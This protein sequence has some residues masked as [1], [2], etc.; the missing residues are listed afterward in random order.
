MFRIADL[1]R[2]T[3]RNH[4]TG[5]QELAIQRKKIY[6]SSDLFCCSAD[7]TIAYFRVN[8]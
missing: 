1:I 8:N 5:N 7:R 3:V 2:L 4:N 6:I